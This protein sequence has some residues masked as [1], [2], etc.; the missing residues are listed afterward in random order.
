MAVRELWTKDDAPARKALKSL[1]DILGRD[2]LC[3]PQ[4]QILHELL[5]PAYPDDGSAVISAVASSV[6]AWCLGVSELLEDDDDGEAWGESLLEAMEES[7]AGGLKLLL[8]V[9]PVGCIC[10]CAYEQKAS[11]VLTTGYG[12]QDHQL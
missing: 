1:Q 5:L 2:V 9:S 12:L 6:Q 10:G 11:G 8:E 3:D 4:W 7:R